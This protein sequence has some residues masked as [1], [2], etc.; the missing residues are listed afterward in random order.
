MKI[1]KIIGKK[2]W[3]RGIKHLY[4]KQDWVTA[5]SYGWRA[6]SLSEM[7]KKMRNFLK[8]EVTKEKFVY[9]AFKG[10]VAEE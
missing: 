8:H 9:S 5:P 1:I 4:D 3:D 10:I 2:E 6:H 7:R